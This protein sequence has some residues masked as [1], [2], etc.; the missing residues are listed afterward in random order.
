MSYFGDKN[1][2]PTAEKEMSGKLSARTRT[3]A[4]V[5]IG[6]GII[7]FFMPLITVNSREFGRVQWS[8]LDIALRLA[9][10]NS[11]FWIESF[12]IPFVL[13]Y[14]ILVIALIVVMV[15]PYPKLLL[16]VSIAGLYPL[17]PFRGFFGG[18]RLLALVESRHSG[19]SSLWLALTIVMAAIALLAWSDM[20]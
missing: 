4:T 15:I 14:L 17:L 10:T 2:K 18:L 20:K 1:N 6:I 16:G 19:I 9:H 12:R 3:A 5:F 11:S 13:T 7:T 8:D